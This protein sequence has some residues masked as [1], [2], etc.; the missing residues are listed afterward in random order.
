MQ[1][2]RRFFFAILA[3]TALSGCMTMPEDAFVA[4]R[5]GI[6]Q[7]AEEYDPVQITVVRGGMAERDATG[8]IIGPLDVRIVYDRE[9]GPETREARI[10]C[11]V[12]QDGAVVAVM[13]D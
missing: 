13:E 4:C 1:M 10:E 5:S 3:S 12:N 2:Y 7:W 8:D 6:H 11:R 9:G